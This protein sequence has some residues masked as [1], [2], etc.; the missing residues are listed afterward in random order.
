MFLC[1]KGANIFILSMTSPV[2][3]LRTLSLKDQLVSQDDYFTCLHL[4]FKNE[5]I[6]VGSNE[7]QIIIL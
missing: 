7:G 2:V 4:D 5:F 3:I 1:D 6:M